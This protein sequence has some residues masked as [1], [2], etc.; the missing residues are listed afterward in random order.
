MKRLLYGLLAVCLAAGLSSCSTKGSQDSE[1]AFS[2]VSRDFFAMNTYIRL[3]A[4]G[5]GAADAL[6]Q[7]ET[8]VEELEGLWSV[9]NETSEIYAVNHSEGQPVSVSEDT[10][11]IISFALD[12][13]EETGGAL[14]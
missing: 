10:A 5:D 3:E 13:A 12:M 2:P 9:T 1:D 14:E 4:Y 7:A 8:R 11:E 6:A